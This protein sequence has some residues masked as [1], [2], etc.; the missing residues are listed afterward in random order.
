MGL[1]IQSNRLDEILKELE[2]PSFGGILADLRM[3]SAWATPKYVWFLAKRI[4]DGAAIIQALMDDA[5]ITGSIETLERAR[6][7]L[8]QLGISRPRTVTGEI[9]TG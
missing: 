7:W 4:F 1:A 5:E 9:Q 8:E 2:P 6:I 3:S